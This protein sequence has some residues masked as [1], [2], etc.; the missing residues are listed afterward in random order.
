MFSVC[1]V[2]MLAE[3]VFHKSEVNNSGYLPN[4]KA[5]EVNILCCSPP[6]K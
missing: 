1:F 6:L 3:V 4:Y 5:V 2:F